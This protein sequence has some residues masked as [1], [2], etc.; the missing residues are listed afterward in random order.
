[1]S[2]PM[3]FTSLLRVLAG[4][5]VVLALFYLAL[6]GLKRM[7]PGGGAP[8]SALRVVAALGVSPRERLLLVQVGEQQ[9]LLGSGPQGLNCL[10]VLPTPIEVAPGSM[11]PAFQG[12]LKRTDRH[13]TTDHRSP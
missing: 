2:D 1:M 4:L 8:E 6:R 7:Q 3:S 12:W 10:H 11:A 5:A 13:P 9:L